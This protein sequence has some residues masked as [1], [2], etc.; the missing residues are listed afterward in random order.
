MKKIKHFLLSGIFIISFILTLEAIPLVNCLTTTINDD[1]DDVLKFSTQEQGDFIDEID[2]IKLD[3]DGQDFNLTLGGDLE[4]IS[5][6][7]SS[8]EISI[9]IF[10]TYNTLEYYMDQRQ[11]GIIYRTL[12]DYKVELRK[13]VPHNDGFTHQGWDNDTSSFQNNILLSD[14]VGSIAG[15]IISATVPLAAFEVLDNFTFIV[16]TW[17]YDNVT[18]YYDIMPNQYSQYARNIGG[19]PGYNIL[20][21]FGIIFSIVS[22]IIKKRLK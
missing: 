3:I 15:G 22:I 5:F 20:I 2:I 8:I 4:S 10:E 11:Y 9:Y 12:T 17:Y 1:Q 21:L 7:H 14:P 19:I 6:E 16:E 13:Y 18:D